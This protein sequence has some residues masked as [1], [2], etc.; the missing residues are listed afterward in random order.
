MASVRDIAKRSGVSTAT[1]SRVLNNHPRVSEEAREKVLSV[2]NRERYV[3]TVGRRSTT[4]I[5]FLYTAETSI[6]S[7]FDS[8]LIH[9][10][11]QRMEEYGFDL[12]ILAA[13]RVRLPN[14]TFTQMFLR[15]GV[16]GAVLRTTERTHS[17]CET[18]AEEGFPCVVVGDRFDNPQVNFIHTDSRSTSREAVEHL[19]SL[20]HRRIG[21]FANLIDDSDHAD[22]LAGYRE[23]HQAAGLPVDENLVIRTWAHLEGGAQGL[24]RSM[25]QLDPPTALF[26]TDPMAAV[27]AMNEAQSMGLQVPAQLSIVGFDDGEARY[28][29]FPK[30]TSV[31]QNAVTLG[32]EAFDVLNQLLDPTTSDPVDKR[33]TLPAWFEIHGSTAP[34]PAVA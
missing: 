26:I 28:T 32:A 29:V 6:S 2:A 9:G 24:R 18:I 13:R 33:R 25:Q 15:K 3:P 7:Q 23:A 8:S 1:V 30:M 31:C 22:R 20:G 34:A 14:E 4:N 21:V 12:M 19:I 10:M 5:A 17:V 27:G 16:R 11:S